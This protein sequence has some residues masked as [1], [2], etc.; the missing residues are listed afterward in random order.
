MYIEI[1][2]FQDVTPCNLVDFQ[3]SFCVGFHTLFRHLKNQ[4]HIGNTVLNIISVVK[5]RRMK[6]TG[7]TSRMGEKYIQSFV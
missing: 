5:S 1:T 4:D 2:V 7:L 6:W 3:G